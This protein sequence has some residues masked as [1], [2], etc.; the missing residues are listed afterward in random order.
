M[1][2]H[3]RPRR[4]I[5]YMP[6]SNER[7]L[8][9]ARE[10]D[11]DGLI[12]DLEDAVAPSAKEDA[13]DRALA[14]IAQGG[15]GHREVVLRI[16]ALSSPW[17]PTDLAAAATSGADAI[18]LPKIDSAD[19]LQAAAQSLRQA[20][21]PSHLALWAMAET[22]LGIINIVGIAAADPR[23]QVLVMGTSDLGKAL[24][25][26]K[27][28]KRVGLQAAL[29][30]CVLA[31]RAHGLD[32]LDGVYGDLTNEPAF[33]AACEQGK[34]LGFDG[35]TL[36]HP[37]QISATNEIFGVSAPE[38]ARARKIVDAW[39]QAAAAGEGIAVADG[40]MIEE[41]HAADARRLLA[42]GEAIAQR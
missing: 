3:P 5:L 23:L 10:L 26:P 37:R 16:N 39:E 18:L 24:R 27:D 25:L 11:I 1:T 15:Y 14:T 9:K 22:P 17:G 36:I 41:L 30:H 4:S 2:S 12:L 21:A 28:G 32:I 29:A 6:A 7:A 38:L 33:R 13:R 35:K 19:D 31:A 20:G 34:A 8:Q 40:Q 42:L